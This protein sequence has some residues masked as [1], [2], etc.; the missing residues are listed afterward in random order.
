MAISSGNILFLMSHFECVLH[1]KRS[2]SKYWNLSILQRVVI[3]SGNILFL[4]S[5]FE[6]VL[7]KDLFLNTGISVEI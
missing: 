4:M 7:W 3:S 2:L 1:L 5:H 6:G